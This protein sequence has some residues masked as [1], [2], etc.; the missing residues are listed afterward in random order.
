MESEFGRGFITNIMLISKHFALPPE[1][2]WAGVSDHMTEFQVPEQF[3][4]TDVE[5]LVTMLRKNIMWHQGGRMDKEDAQS[6]IRILK[7]LVVAIDLH[8]GIAD[9][10]VGKYD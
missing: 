9:P 5:E 8:L 10:H 3:L 4:G 2:A 7:R 6:V 1:Q